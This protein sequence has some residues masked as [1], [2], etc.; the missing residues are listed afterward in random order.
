M[1]DMGVEMRE[2]CEDAE[3]LVDSEEVRF[4]LF[5]R[6][7]GEINLLDARPWRLPVPRPLKNLRLK[8]WQAF[9]INHPRYFI[10]L[11][12]FNAKTVALVQ[13]KVYDRQ[14]GIKHVFEKKVPS[15]TMPPVS[16]L[17]D[18]RFAWR[19]GQEHVVFRNLLREGRISISLHLDATPTS[20]AIEAEIV[21]DASAVTPLVVSIPFAENRGMYSHKGLV[22]VSGRLRVGSEVSALQH[23]DS[24]LLIDDHKGYYPW[25]MRWDWVTAG[26]CKDGVIEGFNL[27]KN[28]SIDPQR[29]HECAF[30]RDGQLHH[31]A[32]V[33]FTRHHEGEDGEYWEIRDRAGMVDLTFTPVVD[34]RVDLNLLVVESRYRG[35]F[36]T[37]SG[38]LRS[39]DGVEMVCDG[40]FGMGEK[41][42][43][44]M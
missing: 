11:A 32:P 29:F 4:G 1:A 35:P 9:Q 26:W 41:F 6:A 18:S 8:E 23:D 2:V 42:Y 15:W 17:R 39:E 5:D 27:T 22:P 30:W 19:S 44:R 24:C 7:I 34:G 37:F 14:K 43:L 28:D 25:V 38:R 20:E 10:M 13:A 36:G 40:M 31:L 21:A 33:E 12:L 3:R 16:T